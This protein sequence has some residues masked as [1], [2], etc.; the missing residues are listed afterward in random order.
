MISK[1]VNIYS[2]I[3]RLQQMRI[4]SCQFRYLLHEL[5]ELRCVIKRFECPNTLH[6]FSISV[7]L[8]IL[9]TK[10]DRKFIDTICN[11]CEGN[12]TIHNK[13]LYS[14]AEELKLQSKPAVMQAPKLWLHTQTLWKLQ[15][16]PILN[17]FLFHP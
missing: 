7:I 15:F 12:H 16:D 10:R 11:V 1:L 5:H 14:W 8:R 3:I 13:K 9:G 17:G 4:S 6:Y 2:L